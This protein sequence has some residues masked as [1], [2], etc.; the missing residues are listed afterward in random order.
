MKRLIGVLGALLVLTPP[1]FAQDRDLFVVDDSRITTAS[2]LVDLGKLMVTVN[3][4]E[5]DGV[6]YVLDNTGTVVGTTTFGTVVDPEALAPAGNGE[7]WVGDIGDNTKERTSISVFKVPVAADDQ[8]VEAPEYSLTYPDGP[9]N[10]ETLLVDPATQRLYV[11]TK[12]KK[13]SIVYAAPAQLSESGTNELEQVAQ[14]QFGP[15]DGAVLEDGTHVVL[16]DYSM[17]QVYTFPDFTAMGTFV[18]PGQVQGEGISVGR[19]QRIRLISEGISQ[20]MIQTQI[21]AEALI[22]AT[23]TATPSVTP[24]SQPS[25][26]P[27]SAQTSPAWRSSSLVLGIAAVLGALAL[28]ALMWALVSLRRRPYRRAAPTRRAERTD[29]PPAPS[30]PPVGGKRSK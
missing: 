21:P 25:P 10:A 22:E 26:T 20:P 9:K 23:P 16:R 27:T 24:T 29:H 3:S 28:G 19:R 18:L 8:T 14:V 13:K 11:V 2:G 30:R 7:V 6:L 1:A 5:G 12:G 15:T 17:G 4:S